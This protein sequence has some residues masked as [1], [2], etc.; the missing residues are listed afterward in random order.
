M[1]IFQHNEIKRSI[2]LKLQLVNISKI[3]NGYSKD[4]VILTV[5]KSQK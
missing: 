1:N 4:L 2:L 3:K 5:W